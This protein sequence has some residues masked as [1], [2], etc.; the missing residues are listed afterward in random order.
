MDKVSEEKV[1]L[2]NWN[3]SFIFLKKNISK[4]GVRSFLDLLFC[5]VSW[6]IFDAYY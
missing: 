3:Y 4:V 6:H 2:K 5:V 1:G